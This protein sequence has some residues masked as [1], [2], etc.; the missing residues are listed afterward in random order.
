[1]PFDVPTDLSAEELEFFKKTAPSKGLTFS[2]ESAVQKFGNIFDAELNQLKSYVQAK[3]V[4]KDNARNLAM[5]YAKN[6]YN[7]NP[8]NFSPGGMWALEMIR[9]HFY[10]YMGY[11][12]LTVPSNNDDY[13]SALEEAYKIHEQTTEH[14]KTFFQKNNK[15]HR[16]KAY[17]DLRTSKPQEI[18]FSENLKTLS[19]IAKMYRLILSNAYKHYMQNRAD[20]SGRL[21]LGLKNQYRG[22]SPIFGVQGKLVPFYFWETTESGQLQPKPVLNYKSKTSVQYS[23]NNKDRNIPV[24]DPS[25]RPLVLSTYQNKPE[26]VGDSTSSV[27]NLINNLQ[28]IIPSNLATGEH[29]IATGSETFLA[30]LKG[31]EIIKIQ[32]P[33]DTNWVIEDIGKSYCEEEGK[34]M[35]HCGNLDG[36]TDK[37]YTIYSVREV[38]VGG[39]SPDE[40]DDKFPYLTITAKKKDKS[41]HAMKGK[42]N[43]KPS[44]EGKL[45]AVLEIL[46][47]LLKNPGLV[48]VIVG[49]SHNPNADITINDFSDE[50]LK[51]IYKSNPDLI[52]RQAKFGDELNSKMFDS[53]T[54]SKYR[55][56]GN[57]HKLEKK[58]YEQIISKEKDNPKQ[59]QL[60]EVY[61]RGP[62]LYRLVL[63]GKISKY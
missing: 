42:E 12:E 4:V 49:D 30:G 25:I 62:A 18:H 29:I 10:F 13:L 15:Q 52:H 59:E 14:S 55:Q 5:W 51:E 41:I 2:E 35:K 20:Y 36:Q 37:G 43:K 23:Y 47:E 61:Y 39:T 17:E 24:V 3:Q 46:T 58:K 27:Y 8:T 6:T 54:Q 1:M 28:N 48:S 53:V 34:A 7:P 11:L 38:V 44:E 19:Y 45:A 63:E 50:Q 16:F 22:P 40:E 60:A 57:P 9:Q 26:G 33:V 56:R 21:I 32:R 31:K